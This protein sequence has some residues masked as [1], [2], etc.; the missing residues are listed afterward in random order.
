[1]FCPS[2]AWRDKAIR[3]GP[4]VKAEQL[5]TALEI[6]LVPSLALQE[7]LWM[8]GKPL[9]VNSDR[10]YYLPV[11]AHLL[12][13]GCPSHLRIPKILGNSHLDRGYIEWNLLNAGS[14]ICFSLL[15]KL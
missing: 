13:R 6:E 1:M 4:E 11:H 15:N 3:T 9:R 8:E 14:G 7:G 2:P 5:V 10:V 12:P